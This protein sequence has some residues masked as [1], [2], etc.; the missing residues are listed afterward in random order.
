MKPSPEQIIRPEILEL[1]AYH[2]AESAGM[3]KLDAMEN[4]YS[5]PQAISKSLAERLSLA[6]INRYP[7]AHGARL[8]AVLRQA[9]DIPQGMEILLGNGSDEI[10][11]ILGLALAKPGATLVSVEPSFVMY[12]MVAIFCGLNYVGVP[13]NSDYSLNLPAVEAAIQQHQPVLI[14]LAYPNNPTGNLFDRVAMEAVIESA[15]GVVVVDEAYFPFHDQSFISRLDRYPNLLLMRTVSKLGLA[16]LRLGFLAG[17]RQ[18]VEQLEKVRLPYNVNVM[19]Q[20]SAELIL[21]DLGALREQTSVIRSDRTRLFREL[22]SIPGVEAFPSAANFILFRVNA[23]DRVFDALRQ[24]GI[25]VKNLAHAHAL[26][27]NCLR[28]TVGTPEENE[29]FVNAL[30]ESLVL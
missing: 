9:M 20:L 18:W 25:L 17:A 4:P 14:F 1:C 5:L 13:L 10:I 2:V 11:Q 7:D 16:G 21:S 8:K 26:L 30:K 15:P 27:V 6:H 19:T 22:V 3:V 23:A 12:K 28:V 24:R 29:R